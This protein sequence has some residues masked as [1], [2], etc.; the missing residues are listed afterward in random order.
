MVL[1]IV[2]ISCGLLVNIFV[3][4]WV[5]LQVTNVL[6]IGLAVFFGFFWKDECSPHDLPPILEA[7]VAACGEAVGIGSLW[8]FYQT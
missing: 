7:E 8:V 6:W 2:N 3:L 5:L 4:G 1:F